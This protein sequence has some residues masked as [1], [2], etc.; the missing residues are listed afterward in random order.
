MKRSTTI[1]V[2]LAMLMTL[3]VVP[4][5]ASD[6][7]EP[8][9][10][11]TIT[12]LTDGQLMTP[13]V[14]ATH[15]RSFR[16]WRHR[17]AASPGLAQLAENGGVPVLVDE[18]NA[19]SLVNQVAVAGGGPIAPGGSA[20]VIIG[21]DS[22]GSRLSLAGML[23][24]TNDGFASIRNARLGGADVRTFYGRAYDAGSEK[25]TE[26]YADLVP[27]CD[28]LGQTG[29]SNPAIAENGVVKVHHGIKG[30]ADLDPS[31]HDWDNPVIKVTVEYLGG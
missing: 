7:E 15:D 22:R 6:Y 31:V 11:V 3:M 28:G 30:R 18:L 10:R 20:E 14:V 13:M 19:N 8:T 17:R 5:S 9:F 26:A 23:I 29:M 25:N 2:A 21:S 24:C 16:L 27:P 1:V 4:A 12:N